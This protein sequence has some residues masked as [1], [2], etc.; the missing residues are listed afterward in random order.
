MSCV[1]ECWNFHSFHCWLTTRDLKRR[2]DNQLQGWNKDFFL[3]M[4]LWVIRKCNTE[5]KYY[6]T[7]SNSFGMA[8]NLSAMYDWMYYYQIHDYPRHIKRMCPCFLQC[9]MSCVAVSAAWIVVNI[10]VQMHKLV[11]YLKKC[12]VVL[13]CISMA[14]GSCWR[15]HLLLSHVRAALWV[16]FTFLL[17]ENWAFQAQQ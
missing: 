7:K 3:F 4:R 16:T 2:S 1:S 12:E 14:E 13:Y 17:R 6:L 11:D 10:K 5:S 8:C 15:C 9:Y